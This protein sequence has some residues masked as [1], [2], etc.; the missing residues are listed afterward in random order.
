M[1]CA[2]CKLK[3]PGNA[4]HNSAGDCIAALRGRLTVKESA[5]IEARRVASRRRDSTSVRVEQLEVS[6]EQIQSRFR[7][8]EETCGKSLQRA[9]FAVGQVARGHRES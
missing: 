1:N 6:M 8:V 7:A 3:L 4:R 2:I 5:L 9:H